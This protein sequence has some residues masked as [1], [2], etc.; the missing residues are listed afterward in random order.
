[1]STLRGSMWETGRTLQVLRAFGKME[2]AHCLQRCK[3]KLNRKLPADMYIIF[4][5]YIYIYIHIY[6][7]KTNINIHIYIYIHTLTN[8]VTYSGFRIFTSL[9]KRHSY[10]YICFCYFDFVCMCV[11]VW[12]NLLRLFEMYSICFWFQTK[13][14]ISG[15][16]ALSL[17]SWHGPLLKECS[18]PQCSAND[19]QPQMLPHRIGKVCGS[20]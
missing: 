10:F 7:H 11:C 14:Y 20:K 3:Q 17:R 8:I 16:F 19:V 2:L 13:F 12:Y 5:I 9:H 1:M 4:I 15:L 6:T 18:N